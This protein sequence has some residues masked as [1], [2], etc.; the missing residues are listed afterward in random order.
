MSKDQALSLDDVLD[1]FAAESDPFVALPRYLVAYPDHALDLVDLAREL[2]RA[3]AE[4]DRVLTAADDQSIRA[5]WK[6]HQEAS[7][8]DPF[9]GLSPERM[10][11]VAS[12]LAVPRQVLMAFR[13][14]LV[15]VESVPRRFLAR[16]AAEVGRSVAAL[17]A[18]LSRPG[19][20]L[21]RSFKADAR[22]IAQAPVSFERLLVDAEVPEG[23]RLALM[24]DDSL[25][26][27]R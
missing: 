13:E 9:A 19:P 20:T 23:E 11:E 26:T 8:S 3:G 15:I 12:R 2:R 14:R 16:L 5:A 17:Q 10:R 24:A 22:P 7:P 1:A 6:K 18:A 25:P 4:T 27:A 21:A